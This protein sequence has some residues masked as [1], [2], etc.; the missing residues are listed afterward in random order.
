[1]AVLFA[2]LGSAVVEVTVTVFVIVDF[3]V[4]FTTM[5]MVA[6]APMPNEPTEH[7][8]FPALKLQ[9]PWVDVAEMNVVVPGKVSVAE[10]PAA[11]IGPLLVTTMV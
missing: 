11:A 5:V 10:T 6:L 4:G 1:M 8:T 7:V 3:F 2:E 9:V